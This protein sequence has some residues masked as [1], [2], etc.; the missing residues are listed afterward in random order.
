MATHRLTL[1]AEQVSE[2]KIIISKRRHSSTELWIRSFGEF[3]NELVVTLDFTQG[4]YV[5][6]CFL[7]R[8]RQKE[9]RIKR[10]RTRLKL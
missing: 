1:K 10:E 7:N 2:H 8:K 5:I 6:L 9:E 3:F 4:P